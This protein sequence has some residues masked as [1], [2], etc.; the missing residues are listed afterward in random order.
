MK[1]LRKNFSK[2]KYNETKPFE[3]PKEWNGLYDEIE[4]NLDVDEKWWGSELPKLV[5]EDI[6][7]RAKE[8][9]QEILNVDNLF[10][11]S[12]NY[13]DENTHCLSQ[14]SNKWVQV[15]SK[16]LSTWDR[17]NYEVDKPILIKSKRKVRYFVRIRNLVGHKYKGKKYS[18]TI[19]LK[20]GLKIKLI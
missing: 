14:F 2:N 17:F 8:Y 18:E 16:K 5:S 13:T 12:G 9:K 10:S 6:K 20:C 7:N 3:I 19:I 15:W 4:V 11:D 1:I